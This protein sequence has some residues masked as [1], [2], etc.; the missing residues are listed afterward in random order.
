MRRNKEVAYSWDSLRET[1]DSLHVGWKTRC[2][3]KSV[4]KNR[5]LSAVGDC[6]MLILTAAKPELDAVLGY[7]RPASRGRDVLRGFIGQETYYVGRYGKEGTVVTMCGMGAIGR[8]SVIL[9]SQQAV[10]LFKPKAMIMIGIA[11]GRDPK[12]QNLGDVL[13]ASHVIAYEPQRVSKSQVVHR[14]NIT[15]VG[16]ILLNR[17][18]NVIDWHFS[19]GRKQESHFYIGPL[20]SG[21]KLIDRKEFKNG[22]FKEFPQ[23]IGGEM[24]GAGL[25]AVAA[26]AGIEWIVVKGICD[27]ADGAKNDHAQALAAHAAA[28]LVLHVL[29]D[30]N[31]LDSLEG[32]K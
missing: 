20:L 28:F 7:L 4:P 32:T 2:R 17:F 5:F 31:A 9:A 23:A 12:R 15:Q 27:W 8:D 19:I 10:T 26:R 22:L 6:P 3:V 13:V 16:P 30:P 24:E 21:E 11:F 1:N 29:S 14:G 18:R 25:S